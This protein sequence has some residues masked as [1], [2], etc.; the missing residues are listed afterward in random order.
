MRSDAHESS[1]FVTRRVGIVSIHLSRA[2]GVTNR[3]FEPYVQP[4]SQPK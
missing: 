2:A 4:I 1:P 3:V